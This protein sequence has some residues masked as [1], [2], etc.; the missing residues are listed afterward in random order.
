MIGMLFIF[1]MAILGWF[2]GDVWVR[3]LERKVKK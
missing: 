1:V 3:W 2:A